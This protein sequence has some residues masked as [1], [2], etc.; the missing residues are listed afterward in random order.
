M[1]LRNQIIKISIRDG[2]GFAEKRYCADHMLQEN[3]PPS[4][5]KLDNFRKN[6]PRIL[7]K[8]MKNGRY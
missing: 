7:I 2:S 6:D 8:L 3:K 5:K 1:L 4:T